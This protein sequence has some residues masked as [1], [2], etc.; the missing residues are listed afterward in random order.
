MVVFGKRKIGDGEPCFIT[1][2]AGPTHDGLKS[3]KRLVTLA[4]EA[5]ADAIK[6]QIFDADRLISDKKQMLSY[7]ILVDRHSGKTERVTEPLYDILC[8]R[9]LGKDEWK[10]VKI[11]SDASGLAF[12]A[13]ADF[14]E[15][16]ILM[17]ELGCDSV[18]IA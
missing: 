11:H 3:A 5:G 8:R 14:D 18:K 9:T 1:F 15:D 7:D 10:E 6:F 13:T 4:A 16:I 12:F 17:E 2:E